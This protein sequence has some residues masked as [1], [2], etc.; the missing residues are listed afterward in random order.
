MEII[1]N[2]SSLCAFQGLLQSHPN[3]TVQDAVAVM[4]GELLNDVTVSGGEP[5]TLLPGQ[6]CQTVLACS[7]RNKHVPTSQG[8][9]QRIIMPDNS[10]FLSLF[11]F[12]GE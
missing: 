12:R 7:V 11:Q 10:L 6:Q 4:V 5:R 3:S 8:A 2:I 9:A 1:R